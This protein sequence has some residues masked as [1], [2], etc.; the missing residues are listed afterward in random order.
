MTAGSWITMD[1]FKIIGDGFIA[2]PVLALSNH[3]LGLECDIDLGLWNACGIHQLDRSVDAGE[4]YF[5]EDRSRDRW[6]VTSIAC[7]FRNC[8][9]HISV[10]QPRCLMVAVDGT[11]I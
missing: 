9:K 7:S 1:N 4:R 3:A 11:E 8:L 10:L 2:H 6:T 5:A